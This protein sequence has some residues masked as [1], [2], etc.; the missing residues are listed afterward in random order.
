MNDL[1]NMV[2]QNDHTSDSFKRDQNTLM[3]VNCI[4]GY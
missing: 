4:H 2:S 3:E 1:E